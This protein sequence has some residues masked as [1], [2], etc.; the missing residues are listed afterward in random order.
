MHGPA[1][2]G[3]FSPLVKVSETGMGRRGG[4]KIFSGMGK[5]GKNDFFF[6]F[7]EGRNIRKFYCILETIFSFSFSISGGVC[8]LW[9][10]LDEFVS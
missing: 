8:G 5:V 10:R 3:P 2:L 4:A 1:R 7:G 6:N 9:V